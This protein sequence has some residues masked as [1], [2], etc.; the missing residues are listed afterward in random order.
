LRQI[1]FEHVQR[2]R[3]D[4]GIARQVSRHGDDVDIRPRLEHFGFIAF[5][6][7]PQSLYLPLG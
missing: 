1:A 3:D 4:D 5:G 6:D 7:R 2:W